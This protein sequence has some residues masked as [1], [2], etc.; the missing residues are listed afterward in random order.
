MK[1]SS[2]CYF[3]NPEI[4]KE[5][6]RKVRSR[7]GKANTTI[8]DRPLPPAK[9]KSFEDV[10]S[11]LEATV[12]LVRSGEINVRTANC[13]GYLS[14]HLSK[15]LEVKERISALDDPDQPEVELTAGEFRR[16]EECLIVSANLDKSV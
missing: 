4:G 11:L 1:S 8:I 13:I 7:G 12:N 9:I 6:K 16:M 2:F 14:G 10:V 3:H 15:A 5:E